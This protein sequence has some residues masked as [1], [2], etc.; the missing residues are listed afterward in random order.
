MPRM[1]R[2]LLGATLC[3]LWAPILS[4]A[5]PSLYLFTAPKNLFDPQTGIY[6]NPTERGKRWERPAS[7]ELV[8]PDDRAG[9]RIHCGLRIHGG[10][11]RRPE[12]SPKHSFRL[13]F[14]AKYGAERLRFPLF[15]PGEVRE[16]KTL[17]LRA[18]YNDSWLYPDARARRRASYLRDEWMRQSMAAMGYPSARGIFVHLYLDRLYWGVYNLCERPDAWFMAAHEGGSAR[19]YD[20]RKA[21]KILS[22][23]AVEWNKMMALANAGLDDRR[24]FD[25]IGRYL[26]LTE[27]ADYMILNYYAGNADWDRDS[28]WYAARRRSRDGGFQFFVWDGECV[29]GDL[30][31]CTMDFDDENSPPGL[32]HKLCESPD[33]RRLFAARIRRLLLD[34]GPLSPQPA[35]ARYQALARQLDDAIFAEA[36]RWGGYRRERRQDGTRSYDPYTTKKDWDRQ[37]ERLLKNYFPKRT[38]VVLRQFQER[39]LYPP[40]GS[41]GGLGRI[42]PRGRS[43]TSILVR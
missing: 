6:A 16:F 31:A 36:A 9:F 11:S 13:L 2:V 25:E 33:F 43:K 24:S 26:D 30:D 42:T 32:F 39:G 40:T 15:G 19:D 4:G 12:E 41:S 10:L 1:L 20:S 5:I 8:Y 22:G 29:L 18:G 23:D 37:V 21:S 35:A 34:G 38:T 27:F 3:A 14:K 17:V 28:N 7:V